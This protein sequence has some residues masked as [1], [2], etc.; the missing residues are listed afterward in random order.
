M[1]KGLRFFR[2]FVSPRN[3]TTQLQAN[4]QNS[5]FHQKRNYTLHVILKKKVSDFL[6]LLHTKKTKLHNYR[7]IFKTHIFTKNETTHYMSFWKKSLW[8]FRPFVSPEKRNYTITGK[9]LK[10]TFS[11]K[12]KPHTTC[13][14]EKKSQIFWLNKTNLSV[15]PI[16]FK[17]SK[18][19]LKTKEIFSESG[20]FWNSLYKE[21]SPSTQGLR[22][23]GCQ[24]KNYRLYTFFQYEWK[25]NQFFCVVLM[26][27]IWTANKFAKKLT[28]LIK[29]HN[30]S[31]PNR[32]SICIS[33]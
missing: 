30:Q 15:F 31:C 19:P 12:T 1:K 21:Y 8:F 17:I 29:R 27:H 26:I 10:G 28:P 20:R 32:G 16:F 11:L 6:G 9:F 24:T 13:H 22:V 7:Q 14:F 25:I 2:P 18:I 23:E 33:K 5:H 3:E 4:S